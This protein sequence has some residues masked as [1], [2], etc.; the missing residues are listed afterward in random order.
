MSINYQ[1]IKS[2]KR[3]ITAW[4]GGTTEEL[5]I[6]PEGSSYGSRN[7]L[8]RVSTAVVEL[9]QSNFTLLPAY[10][11]WIATLDGHITLTHE[12]HG[13]AVNLTP[14]KPHQFKGGW[15]TS[16]IGKC[17]DFN[18]MLA[19]G[20]SGYIAPTPRHFT[21]SEGEFTGIF[22]FD[23]PVRLTLTGHDSTASSQA[24]AAQPDSGRGGAILHEADNT[25][26]TRSIT[27]MLETRDILVIHSPC[28]ISI[29]SSQSQSILF[30]AH[31][32]L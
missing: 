21:C 20:W 6:Y 3:S 17:T 14:L 22:A 11:R 25:N 29:E 8:F 32:D 24:S 5:Y 10:T 13:S 4:T 23:G 26:S 9:E 31:A 18:L 28:D 30:T 2:A 16:C 15:V 12:E 19:E 7:F 27:L 1:I